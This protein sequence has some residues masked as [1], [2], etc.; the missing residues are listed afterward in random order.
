MGNRSLLFMCVILRVIKTY[1]AGS[2]PGGR[3]KETIDSAPHLVVPS[4]DWP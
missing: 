4:I 2:G 3:R 1:R